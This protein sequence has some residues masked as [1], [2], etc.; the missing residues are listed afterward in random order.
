MDD[1]DR[2]GYGRIPAL[3]PIKAVDCGDMI[4]IAGTTTIWSVRS[5]VNHGI[6]NYV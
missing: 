3:N 2:L 6:P 4:R 5:T 1:C